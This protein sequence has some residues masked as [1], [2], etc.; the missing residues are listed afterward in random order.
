MRICIASMPFTELETPSLAAATLQALL[1]REFPRDSIDSRLPY[2]LF[3]ERVGK[4]LYTLM[5]ADFLLGRAVFGMQLYPEKKD[6]VRRYL[7]RKLPEF[8]ELLDPREQTLAMDVLLDRDRRAEAALDPG[9]TAV[10]FQGV[11]PTDDER[12]GGADGLFHYLDRVCGD[13]VA[14]AASMLAA[15]TDLVIFVLGSAAA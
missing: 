12:H 7:R 9:R 2:A 5:A 1:A 4:G 11:A 13:F 8:L 14:K 10:Y 6:E 15:D 3:A